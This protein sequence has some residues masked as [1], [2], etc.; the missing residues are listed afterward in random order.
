[1]FYFNDNFISFIQ[2]IFYAVHCSASLSNPFEW[3]SGAK[4]MEN[5]SEKKQAK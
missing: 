3:K 2:G 5:Q 4:E 1:M